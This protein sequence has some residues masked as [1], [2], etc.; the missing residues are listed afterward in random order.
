MLHPLEN[1]NFQF[2]CHCLMFRYIVIRYIM[3]SKNNDAEEMDEYVSDEELAEEMDIPDPPASPTNSCIIC[4]FKSYITKKPD[5]ESTIT[6][7]RKKSI[8]TVI[9]GL[10]S[11]RW[12][13]R[14]SKNCSTSFCSCKKSGVKCT[15][16]CRCSDDRENF[17]SHYDSCSSDSDS[18]LDLDNI[19]NL[20]N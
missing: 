19:E 5:E 4:P 8:Q 13:C 18:D 6:L 3:D 10:R 14:C 9:I 1:R 2:D 15:Q 7:K 16:V 17:V 20:Q 12:T 11:V